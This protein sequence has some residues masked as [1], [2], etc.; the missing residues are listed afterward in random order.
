MERVG[1]DR[2]NRVHR[3]VLEVH[4]VRANRARLPIVFEAGLNRERESQ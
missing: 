3:K 1:L 2:D 4:H